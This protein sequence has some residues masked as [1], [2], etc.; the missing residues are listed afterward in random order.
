MTVDCK[1]I[2]VTM[3][4]VQLSFITRQMTSEWLRAHLSFVAVQLKTDRARVQLSFVE[5]LL[6]TDSTCVQL[7][8]LVKQLKTKQLQLSFFE[9]SVWLQAARQKVVV[10]AVG[11]HCN[12][13]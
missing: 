1:I 3:L 10:L 4:R 2:S 6:R 9:E 12:K 13:S 5:I 7:S 11:I 8:L